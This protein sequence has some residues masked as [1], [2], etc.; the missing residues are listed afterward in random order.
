MPRFSYVALD[1]KGQEQNGIVEAN[2]SND[3]VAQLRQAG[4]FPTSVIE[5]GKGGGTK[6]AKR[7]VTP[8][9]RPV[10][11]RKS[12]GGMVLFQKS[13]KIPITT[14][15]TIAEN[16]VPIRNPRKWKA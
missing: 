10:A 3:A 14:R 2:S 6:T 9:A 5:E 4:Y 16:T 11:V 12:G 13:Q 15:P 1:A 8:A 7:Q